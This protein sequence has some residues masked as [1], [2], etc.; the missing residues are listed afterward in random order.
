VRGTFWNLLRRK[1]L[2]DVGGIF[3]NLLGTQ[4]F[5]YKKGWCL[6]V[7]EQQEG[8]RSEVPIEISAKDWE[9]RW[10]GK[11][12]KAPYTERN[13]FSFLLY[14]ERVM[15]GVLGFWVWVVFLPCN[16]LILHFDSGFLFGLSPVVDIG[17]LSRTTYICVLCVIAYICYSVFFLFFTSHGS[18]KIGFYF[19]T[20]RWW[21]KTL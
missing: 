2:L 7:C 18:W 8:D 6:C 9:H 16:S 12:E 13:V 1:S 17:L 21:P 11:R 19:L 10:R 14:W 3:L 5:S 4:W 20:R 15:L